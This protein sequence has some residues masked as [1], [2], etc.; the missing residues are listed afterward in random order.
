M[1]PIV[2]E[3]KVARLP[4]RPLI[5]SMRLNALMITRIV[6]I[7]SKIEGISGIVNTPKIPYRL[8]SLTWALNTKIKHAKICP[9]SFL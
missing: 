6:N 2:I 4:E 7:E 9:R 8:V 1:S 3:I 5:P